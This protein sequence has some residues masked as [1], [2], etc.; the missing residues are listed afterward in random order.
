[1]QT[2]HSAGLFVF[3]GLIYRL[4]GFGWGPFWI[5]WQG[6]RWQARCHDGVGIDNPVTGSA[7]LHLCPR[8]WR[9]VHPQISRLHRWRGLEWR[10]SSWPVAHPGGL[11]RSQA[12]SRIVRG[13]RSILGSGLSTFR[14]AELT[15]K[16]CGNAGQM[17]V[18]MDQHH[19]MADAAT[20]NPGVDHGETV[21]GSTAQSDARL[22][23]RTVHIDV[24]HVERAVALMGAVGR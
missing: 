2:G 18:A 6:R 17:F 4:A 3:R 12:K 7:M 24:G 1:M 22:H 23:G 13:S 9:L 5:S 21:P 8:E 14:R 11:R 15:E 16:S 20:G 10:F 19:P